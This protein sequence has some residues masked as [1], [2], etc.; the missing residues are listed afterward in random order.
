MDDP[1]VIVD[2][3]VDPPDEI[4]PV[5]LNPPAPPPDESAEEKR[6]K[7]LENTI[8]G[9][10]RITEKLQRDF[11]NVLQKLD[12][13]QPP[14]PAPVPPAL[15]ADMTLPEK[16]TDEYYEKLVEQGKWQVAVDEKAAAKVQTALKQRD[17]KV[18]E[19][20][21][22]AKRSSIIETSRKRV[23]SKYPDLDPT[24]GKGNPESQAAQLYDEVLNTDQSLFADPRCAE[25]AMYRMEDL[26]KERGIRLNGPT[27]QQGRATGLPSSRGS[28]SSGT[29]N[30][31]REQKEVCDNNNWKYEDFAK[32]ASTLEQGGGIEVDD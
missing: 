10:R 27:V 14:S 13:F 16:G 32:Q 19:D 11:G 20:A 23:I 7:S 29:Y 12:T 24:P 31:T 4:T 1:V 22:V 28:G 25:I 2:P 15:P 17:D 8:A 6:I 21:E 3:P 18:K 5:N 26:A 9:N 30:L